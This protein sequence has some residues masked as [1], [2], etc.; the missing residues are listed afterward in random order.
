MEVTLLPKTL[1]EVFDFLTDQYG[2][3]HLWLNLE[4]RKSHLNNFRFLIDFRVV[5]SS[6]QEL[7]EFDGARWYYINP[8]LLKFNVTVHGLPPSNAGHFQLDKNRI[9]GF[10]NSFGI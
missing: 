4:P 7:A 1:R 9:I 8:C 10:M 2:H 5:S 3:Q 6:G